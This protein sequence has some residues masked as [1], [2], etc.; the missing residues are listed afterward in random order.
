MEARKALVVLAEPLI[1]S[2]LTHQTYLG[3]FALI[4]PQLIL[5]VFELI[6]SEMT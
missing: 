3:R 1:V 2:R 4:P 6:S 5:L